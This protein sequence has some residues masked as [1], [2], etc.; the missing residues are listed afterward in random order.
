M[1][2]MKMSSCANINCDVTSNLKT[3]VCGQVKYCGGKCQKAHWPSHRPNCP[4]YTVT[5]V[6]GKGQGVVATRNVAAGSLILSEKP[7]LVVEQAGLG[8]Q[9][10]T[11]GDMTRAG[12]K[13]FQS[14]N[15]LSVEDRERFLDLSD[16]TGQ[17]YSDCYKAGHG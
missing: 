14:F 16:T 1:S 8:G 12:A 10:M 3:C 11:E 2:S 17:T 7:L 15:N 9:G 4:P 13:L 6:P 5:A